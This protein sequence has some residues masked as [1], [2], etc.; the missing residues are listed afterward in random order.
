[1]CI[2]VCHEEVDAGKPDMADTLDQVTFVSRILKKLGHRVETL[3]FSSDI[4]RFKQSLKEL[5][6]GIVFN[7]VESFEG[8]GYNSFRFPELLESLK[9]PFTGGSSKAL[10]LT[11]D[12]ATMKA[13][14]EKAFVKT[15]K[16]FDA[17]NFVL[18]TYIV[19]ALAEHASIGLDHTCIV[20]AKTPQDVLA[21]MQRKEKDMAGATIA[22]EYIEGAEYIMGMIAGS[23]LPASRIAYENGMKILDYSSKWYDES[24]SFKCTEPVFDVPKEMEKKLQTIAKKC[25]KAFDMK[26][27]AR[28]DFRVNGKGEVFVID[29]NVNP[30]ISA[31]FM[32]MARKKGL[33]EEEVLQKILT[34]A[35]PC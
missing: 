32:N 28:V 24:N 11:A 18:G 22:E 13:V 5:N 3:V 15:P 31:G 16:T 25:W 21:V 30:C 27:Y 34:E 10:L 8:K 9:I 2:V 7:M 17:R 29:I 26:G 4:S 20:D 1:M 14:L 12:K 19:K 35:C 6:P 23:P 33:T